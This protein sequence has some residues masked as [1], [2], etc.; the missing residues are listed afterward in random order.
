[1]LELPVKTIVS[2]F[3]S[4]RESFFWVNALTSSLKAG[5]S[6]AESQN[7]DPKSKS[8]KNMFELIF[9]LLSILVS[10]LE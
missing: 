4:Q 6:W 3:W 9:S 5:L 7:T 2:L 8:K 10:K 1:M